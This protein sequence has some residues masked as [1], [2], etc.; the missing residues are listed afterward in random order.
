M[1]TQR[2]ASLI[3]FALGWLLLTHA[4]GS[5]ASVT[6]TVT[7]TAVISPTFT[8]GGAHD[9]HAEHTGTAPRL[10]PLVDPHLLRS[11]TLVA[12]ETAGSPRIEPPYGPYS[13]VFTSDRV[14]EDERGII[15]AGRGFTSKGLQVSEGLQV[16][17]RDGC[18]NHY[19]GYEVSGEGALALLMPRKTQAL[20][21][22]APCLAQSF[23]ALLEGAASYHIQG[24]TLRITALDDRSGVRSVLTF[25]ATPPAVDAVPAPCP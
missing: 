4:W 23:P 7:V 17:A 1:G 9:G 10:D 22:P 25:S 14:T 5:S 16:Y 3:V 24:D 13:V 19:G 6:Y 20:C 15:R 21:Q 8:A 11:W 12:I 2:L 18:N